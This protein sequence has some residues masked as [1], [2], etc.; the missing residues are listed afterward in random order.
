MSRAPCVIYTPTQEE[1][2][3]LVAR[4]AGKGAPHLNGSRCDGC[5]KI[6]EESDMGIRGYASGQELGLCRKCASHVNTPHNI[7]YA[8][9]LGHKVHSKPIYAPNSGP[10][11]AFSEAEE[12]YSE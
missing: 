2:D 6:M 9:K 10:Q 1:S 4:L 5:N 3:D 8:E 12:D 11:Q 7:E